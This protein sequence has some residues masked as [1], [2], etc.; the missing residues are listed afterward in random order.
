MAVMLR[1]LRALVWLG[2]MALIGLPLA[3]QSGDPLPE[4]K[5]NARYSEAQGC[6]EPRD[7]MRKNHM[8]YILHQRDETMHQGIRTRQH[9]LEECIN[10]HVV[11][12]DSG[13]VAR[14]DSE[15]HFCAGCHTYTAVKIDCFQCHADRPVQKTTFHP[16]GGKAFSHH[17]D[18]PT[19]TPVSTGMLE[20]LAEEGKIQ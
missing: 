13:Q 19:D 5:T 11:P 12:N 9:A 15:E 2:G 1:K 18:T 10:C 14:I 16:L 20:V 17:A 3:A 4:V 8:Q 6:V 7:E